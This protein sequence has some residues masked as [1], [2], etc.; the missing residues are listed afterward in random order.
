MLSPCPVAI[1]R[2]IGTRPNAA[3][4]AWDGRGCDGCRVGIGRTP[5]RPET[6]G[7]LLG[8]TG[9]SLSRNSGHGAIFGAQRSVANDPLQTYRELRFKSVPATDGRSLGKCRVK[10][11]I[12]VF[13]N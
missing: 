13:L 1:G 8:R 12:P 6:N 4:R 9:L 10:E 3:L 5:S 11:L 7:C 2:D